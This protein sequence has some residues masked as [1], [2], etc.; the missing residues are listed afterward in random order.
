MAKFEP[1]IDLVT[2]R[3]EGGFQNY[4]NDN[5]NWIVQNGKKIN[6]GTNHGIAGTTY[7]EYRKM[8]GLKP[9]T[10]TDVRNMTK[11]EA[12]NI[13]KTMFWDKYSFSDIKYQGIAEFLFDMSLGSS[14]WI[15]WCN[16]ALNEFFNA[17]LP[18]SNTFTFGKRQIDL[19]NST[20]N[21]LGLLKILKKYRIEWYNA[22]VKADDKQKD[23][24]N[25]WLNRTNY[26]F[27]KWK[28]SLTD[29][30]DETKETVKKNPKKTLFLTIALI[31]LL[32]IAMFGVKKYIAI[33]ASTPII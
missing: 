2:D 15:K 17:S 14:Y 10:E 23:F 19:I 24:L 33:S 8:K 31:G 12:V 30:I 26:M 18:T 4:A 6:I 20:N 27:D 22:I 9:P 32:L 29:V 28:N 16:K 11:S 3:F 13:F 21:P 1:V 5:G 25:S 7:T